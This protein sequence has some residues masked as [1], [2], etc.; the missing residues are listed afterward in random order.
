MVDL[1]QKT[2]SPLQFRQVCKSYGDL[3][4][5]DRLTLSA[6][7]GEVLGFLGPNG[8][9]KTTTIRIALGLLRASSGEARLFGEESW[10]RAVSVRGRVGYLPGDVRL[11]DGHTGRSLLELLTRLRSAG[12]RA[13]RQMRIQALE[14]SERLDLELGKAVRTYS[15]GNKQKLGLVQALMHQPELLILDEPTS[16]LDP[17]IQERVYELIREQAESGV[18]VFFSSHILSEVEKVCDRVSIL[19]QGRL[20]ETRRVSDMRDFG[21][22]RAR[23]RSPD[24]ARASEELRLAGFDP[25][26]MAASAGGVEVLVQG[27]YDQLIAALVKVPVEDLRIEPLSLEEIFFDL[28]EKGAP[29]PE[30]VCR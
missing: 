18:A 8:A 25:H 13:A 19:R 1:V 12:S 16:A 23:I 22:R 20:L 11:Y 10:R 17:L 4:A 21:L 28:Y 27:Q 2:D 9:G 7:R 14:L 24:P 5:L 15:K 26:P 3:R 29:E 6:E 30:A